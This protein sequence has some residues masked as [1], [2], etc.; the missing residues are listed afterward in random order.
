M[1]GSPSLGPHRSGRAGVPVDL[2]REGVGSSGRAA[3]RFAVGG[4]ADV[5]V[6]DVNLDGLGTFA[7]CIGATTD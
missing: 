5:L 2:T 4:D 6:A 1:R 3:G 7:T